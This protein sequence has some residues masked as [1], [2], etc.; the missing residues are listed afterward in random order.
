MSLIQKIYARYSV[1][2]C[3]GFD[4]TKLKFIKQG[5]SESEIQRY[6]DAFK[7]LKSQNKIKQDKDK[8]IDTWGK[9]SFS[10]FKTYINN[11]TSQKS[12]KE[13]RVEHK[14]GSRPDR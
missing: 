11:A 14:T 4:E 6:F 7:K 1:A 3:A 13:I 5:A 8:D 2:I 10:D 12:N 9:R